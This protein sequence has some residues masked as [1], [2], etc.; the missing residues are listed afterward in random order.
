[1]LHN[2]STFAT[3]PFFV[4]R[5][6]EIYEDSVEGSLYL[7]VKRENIEG[8]VPYGDVNINGHS[9]CLGFMVKF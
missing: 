9:I 1:M 4:I 6:R 5:Y 2:T 3:H 8:E 7:M